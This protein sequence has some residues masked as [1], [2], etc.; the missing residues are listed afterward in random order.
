MIVVVEFRLISISILNSMT[1]VFIVA[2]VDISLKQEVE[3][4]KKKNFYE[5]TKKVKK[6]IKKKS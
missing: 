1:N 2:I 3:K 5:R 6:R 4:M